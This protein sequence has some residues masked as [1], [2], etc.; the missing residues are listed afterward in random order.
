MANSL[1]DDLIEFKRSKILDAASDLFFRQGYSRT[2]VEEIA[3]SLSVAKPF[4]YSHVASKAELLALV[5]GRT[6]AFAAKLAH[7]AAAGKGSPTERLGRLVYDLAL[8]VIEGHVYL[9]VYFRE[10]KHLPE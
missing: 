10:E 3:A 6:T 1:K 7:D 4:I 9:S 2:T 8:A 5:C